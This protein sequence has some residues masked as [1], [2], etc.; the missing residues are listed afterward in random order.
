MFVV[1]LNW[2]LALFQ[3]IAKRLKMQFVFYYL[4]AYIIMQYIILPYC[5]QHFTFPVKIYYVLFKLRTNQN[6]TAITLIYDN[7]CECI[8]CNRFHNNGSHS[9]YYNLAV[10]FK[11]GLQIIIHAY[12]KQCF[13]FASMLNQFSAVKIRTVCICN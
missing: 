6:Y 5:L 13:K 4:T 9:S 10:N 3:Y 12:L 8:Y 11:H 1:L 2:H 7:I